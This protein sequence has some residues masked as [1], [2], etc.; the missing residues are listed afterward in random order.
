[1]Q[2]FNIIRKKTIGRE[3]LLKSIYFCNKIGAAPIVYIP[4]FLKFLMYFENDV[5]Q[6]D[7]DPSY[8]ANPDT[9]LKHADELLEQ[10]VEKPK[11]FNPK[12]FS[13]ATL[14][15]ASLIS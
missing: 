9:A 6:I 13:A 11:F 10:T 4:K 7:L 8:L 15:D 2:L 3:T 1:M 5:V 14:P 12:N